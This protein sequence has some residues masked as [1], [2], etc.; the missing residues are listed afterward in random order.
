[1]LGHISLI[2]PI[3]YSQSVPYDHV[4]KVKNQ[5]EKFDS[6]AQPDMLLTVLDNLIKF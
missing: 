2:C 6:F 3:K 1:M 5:P 4:F